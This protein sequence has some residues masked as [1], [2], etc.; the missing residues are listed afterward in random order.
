V[1]L[2]MTFYPFEDKPAAQMA[3][4]DGKL[5]LTVE[6]ASEPGSPTFRGS[7]PHIAAIGPDGEIVLPGYAGAALGK[8]RY[9]K[10]FLAASSDG[11]QLFVSGFGAKIKPWNEPLE[12][13]PFIARVKLPDAGPGELFFGDPKQASSDSSHLNEP[14][15][16]ACDGRG[17]LLICAGT[18]RHAYIDDC[19]NRR[20]LRVKLDY[21]TS[22]TVAMP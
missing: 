16:L 8:W 7:S 14:R 17:Q 12:L 2:G 18:D 19:D 9:I 5:Y 4:V 11:K 13:Q 10:P 20:M 15:G 3:F 21:S 22:E 6:P 1:A